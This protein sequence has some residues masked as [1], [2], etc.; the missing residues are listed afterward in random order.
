MLGFL[1][2]REGLKKKLVFQTPAH[3]ALGKTGKAKKKKEVKTRQFY[4]T[5]PARMAAAE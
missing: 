1:L 4:E 3:V 5:H 2:Y